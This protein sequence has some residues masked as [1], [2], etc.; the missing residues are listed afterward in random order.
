MIHA[1]LHRQRVTGRADATRAAR[2]GAWGL[3]LLLG[4]LLAVPAHD[5]WADGQQCLDRVQH[6]YAKKFDDIPHVPAGQVAQLIEQGEDVLLVDVREAEEYGVSRIQGAVRIDPDQWSWDVVEGLREAAEGKTVVLYCSVGYRSSQ[7]AS[8]IREGLLDRGAR[9]VVNM[10]GGIFAWHNTGR[11]LVDAGGNQTPWVH[12]YDRYWARF[13]EF[14]E[15][16][17]MEPGV[18]TGSKSTAVR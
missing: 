3:W 4:T 2:C 17:R 7:M 13:V 5:A 15:L 8:A 6:E 14:P 16:T 1:S 18:Q 11:P 10:I 9:N 12:P